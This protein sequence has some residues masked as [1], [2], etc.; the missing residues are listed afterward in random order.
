MEDLFSLVFSNMFI[1]L[2]IVFGIYSWIKRAALG[3]QKTD[4]KRQKNNPDSE[5]RGESASQNHGQEPEERQTPGRTFTYETPNKDIHNAPIQ[6]DEMKVHIE[7]N[8]HPGSTR[9]SRK[10]K[11]N[12]KS[13]SDGIIMAEILG[14]PRAYKPHNSNY[15]KR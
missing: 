4:S 12:K 3:Q 2:A 11:W 10:I 6:E 9:S 7:K 13:V 5:I 14:P 15:R 8:K 1:L